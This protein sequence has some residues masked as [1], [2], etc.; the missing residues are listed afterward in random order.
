[1]ANPATA[2]AVAISAEPLDPARDLYQD[3]A[4]HHPQNYK[5]VY[6]YNKILIALV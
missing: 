4:A 5:H 3:M 6:H 1:M 2:L